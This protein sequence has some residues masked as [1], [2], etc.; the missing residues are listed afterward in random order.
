MMKKL[1][2]PFL[3]LI[4]LGFACRNQEN[5]AKEKQY[6]E[7][8]LQLLEKATTY[9]SKLPEPKDPTSPLALLGKKLYYEESVSANGKMSCN[10]CHP[11]STYGVDNLPTSPGHDGRRGTRNSPTTFNAYFHVAQFWDGRSPDLADQAK[12]P[13]LNP[14]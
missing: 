1:L 9:F 4:L 11:I 6:S 14:I 3:A 2:F 12:G 7:A 8:D 10:T 13:I 5:K